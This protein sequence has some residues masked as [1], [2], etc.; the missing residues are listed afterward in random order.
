MS[1]CAQINRDN[2]R[3]DS[4]KRGNEIYKVANKD[5]LAAAEEHNDKAINL[6]KEHLKAYRERCIDEKEGNKVDNQQKD[7]S[8]NVDKKIWE[9]RKKLPKTESRTKYS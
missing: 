7:A 9:K 6:Y 5:S 2:L 8:Q 3:Y 4:I 1:G